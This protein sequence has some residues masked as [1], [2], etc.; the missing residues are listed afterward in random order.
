MGVFDNFN[1]LP[2]IAIDSSPLSL[3]KLLLWVSTILRQTQISYQVCDSCT[4]PWISHPHPH[5][6]RIVPIK[7]YKH[8][9][10]SENSVPLHPMVLLIVIPTKW[11]F[12]WGY[13]PFSDIPIYAISFYLLV[14]IHLRRNN[15]SQIHVA[16][17]GDPRWVRWVAGFWTVGVE[18]KKPLNITI[19]PMGNLITHNIYIYTYIYIYVYLQTYI[20]III[21][22]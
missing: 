21:Y 9:G 7:C 5:I 16:K 12:H 22:I 4:F 3:L 6:V 8:M 19:F 17:G 1:R 13:T 18:R 2:P 11:L 15:I 20:Y 14:S 10:L